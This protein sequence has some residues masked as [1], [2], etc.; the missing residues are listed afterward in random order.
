MAQPTLF[1]A[2]STLDGAVISR[3]AQRRRHGEWLDFL[4]QID[5]KTPK[6]KEL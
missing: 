6:K 3:C 2:M 1:A 5:R 4:R